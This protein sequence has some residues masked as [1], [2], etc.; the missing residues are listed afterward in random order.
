METK[1]VHLLTYSLWNNSPSTS[2]EI[3]IHI[4]HFYLTGSVFAASIKIIF[5]QFR[6]P[7]C[8]LIYTMYVWFPLSV[9][10]H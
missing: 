3:N 6:F 7:I 4:G 8:I 1:V 2:T 9:K 5:F 10:M